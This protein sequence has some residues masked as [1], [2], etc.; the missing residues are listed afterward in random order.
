MKADRATYLQLLFVFLRD[1]K[2]IGD[3]VAETEI[4]QGA[5]DMFAGNRLLGFLFA[6]VVGFGG[7]EGDEFNAAFH[8][9]VAG[10]FGKRLTGGRRQDLGDDLLDRRCVAI[11]F[12]SIQLYLPTRA[13]QTQKVV[14]MERGWWMRH[15]RRRHH[16][17]L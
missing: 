16:T 1:S 17:H 11:S 2:N 12:M 9:Q 14:D 10:I 8:E 7:D 6:D 15:G 13:N 4:T 5:L 3:V